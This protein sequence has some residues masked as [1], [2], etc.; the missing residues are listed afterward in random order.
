M[1]IKELTKRKNEYCKYVRPEMWQVT[2]VNFMNEVVNCFKEMED[3][4]GKEQKR[5]INEKEEE[6]KKIK[7]NRR[8]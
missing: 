8:K 7:A 4:Y 3:K 5:K 1:S 6:E 2:L